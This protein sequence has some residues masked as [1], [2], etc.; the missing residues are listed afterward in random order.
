MGRDVSA[1]AE[2]GFLN[3][4]ISDTTENNYGKFPYV[5]LI[6]GFLSLSLS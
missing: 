6:T 5:R 3:S 1:S 4:K 2:S